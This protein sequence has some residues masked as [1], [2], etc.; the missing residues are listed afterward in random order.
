MPAMLRPECL[1]AIKGYARHEVFFFFFFNRQCI[2]RYYIY[3][4]QTCMCV[5]II[6]ICLPDKHHMKILCISVAGNSLFCNVY[7]NL[8]KDVV[9]TSNPLLSV[10]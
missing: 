4:K 8:H 3:K 1:L 6:C 5:K 10:I 7:G 9:I 2:H